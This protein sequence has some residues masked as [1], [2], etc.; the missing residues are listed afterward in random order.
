M[1]TPM[2]ES[3]RR[4]GEPAKPAHSHSLL[5]IFISTQISVLSHDNTCDRD[6][7]YSR[8]SS[9]DEELDCAFPVC[10]CSR[11]DHWRSDNRIRDYYTAKLVKT[12]SCNRRAQRGDVPRTSAGSA[13]LEP[14]MPVL[15]STRVHARG[16]MLLALYGH[17][18][19]RV[20]FIYYKKV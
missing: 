19:L 6:R 9:P 7:D 1:T 12:I 8:F 2:I 11:S 4:T 3:N 5:S 18:L 14:G 20:E 16:K 15:L 17:S 13:R 10:S